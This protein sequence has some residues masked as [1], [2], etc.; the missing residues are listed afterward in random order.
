MFSLKTCGVTP[1]SFDAL[2]TFHPVI[3]NSLQ[4]LSNQI[5]VELI[6]LDFVIIGLIS[7][8]FPTIIMSIF[9]FPFYN[10][11]Y[12]ECFINPNG[13]IGFVEDNNGWNNEELEERR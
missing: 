7:G 8:I 1:Y 12:T 9:E 6:Y 13:W 5:G 3:N 2:H 10:E 11:T 4:K